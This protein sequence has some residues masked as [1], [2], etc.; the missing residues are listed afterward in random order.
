MLN[1]HQKQMK[2]QWDS[3]ASLTD[4]KSILGI[5]P[6]YK[7][8]TRILECPTM[9][10]PALDCGLHQ[11]DESTLQDLRQIILT[12]RKQHLQQVETWLEHTKNFVSKENYAELCDKL[13]KLKNLL[14]DEL[15]V[16]GVEDPR[17][18]AL[19]LKILSK[20]GAPF[21]F[22]GHA[23]VGL[24]KLVA[25]L[26]KMVLSSTRDPLLAEFKRDVN[27]ALFKYID[28]DLKSIEN[29]LNVTRARQTRSRALVAYYK[30]MLEKTQEEL[31]EDV[32]EAEAAILVDFLQLDESENVKDAIKAELR[33]QENKLLEVSEQ[34]QEKMEIKA[35]S[36]EKKPEVI[37]TK[38][39]FSA[40]ITK[41]NRWNV[42]S[43]R[44]LAMTRSHLFIL[45]RVVNNFFSVSRKIR[46][47][48]LKAFSKIVSEEGSAAASEFIIHVSASFDSLCKSD[49]SAE[50]QRAI[51][52]IYWLNVKLNLSVHCISEDVP[53]GQVFTSKRDR[54]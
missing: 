37:D 43:E 21:I 44:V 31:D 46:V 53:M 9:S 51:K 16:L 3:L 6:K 26:G 41:K 11:I 49:K 48:Q 42:R 22:V 7:Y 54:T 30:S 1:L 52:Y 2:E 39:V 34:I 35:A 12:I 25:A 47:D 5:I 38:I 20:I 36:K 14:D 29:S 24:F 8:I 45:Q 17:Q 28:T 19:I 4:M 40:A 27:K 33:P 23:G 50:I 15:S 18:Q 13:A 32:K 10:N